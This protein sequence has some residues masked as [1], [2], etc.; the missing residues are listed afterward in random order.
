[1]KTFNSSKA[2]NRQQ[3]NSYENF[4]NLNQGLT[5]RLLEKYKIKEYSH[6]R[7]DDKKKITI[8]GIA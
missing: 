5:K 2:D 6:K 1:M 8:K 3:K 4:I 7:K